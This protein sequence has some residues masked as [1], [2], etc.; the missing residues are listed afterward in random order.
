MAAGDRDPGLGADLGAAGE[1]RR[2]PS[3]TGSLS[4]GMP[5]TASAMIGRPPIA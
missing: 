5:S 3:P 1:D 4:I 2:A